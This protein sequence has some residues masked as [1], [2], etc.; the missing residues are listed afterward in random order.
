MSLNTPLSRENLF[1]IARQ[2]AALLGGALAATSLK[3]D[4]QRNPK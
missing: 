3:H 1:L 4:C 2:G